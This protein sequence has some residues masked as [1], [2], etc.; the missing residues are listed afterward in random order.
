[1]KNSSTFVTGN[2]IIIIMQ[3]SRFHFKRTICFF[4]LDIITVTANLC[5]NKHIYLE[6]SSEDDERILTFERSEIVKRGQVCHNVVRRDVWV[7][8]KG[9]LIDRSQHD[10]RAEAVARLV[11][12]RRHA[13]PQ[14]FTASLLQGWTCAKPKHTLKYL[15]PDV[16]IYACYFLSSSRRKKENVRHTVGL[17]ENKKQMEKSFYLFI[18]SFII[19]F[20]EHQ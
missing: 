2:I 1:M 19:Y 15:S 14:F 16:K 20:S 6:Q 18:L 7:G 3:L 12:A 9:I 17:H 8:N 13:K 11:A 10:A 5:I 4:Y